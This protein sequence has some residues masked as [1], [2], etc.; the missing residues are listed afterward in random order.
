MKKI[1]LIELIKKKYPSIPEKESFARI[2]C[3]EVFVKGERVRDP[4]RR[5][6]EGAEP[7]FLSKKYVSRGGIKLESVLQRWKIEVR[8]KIFIDAGSST[9]GFTDCLLQ[10]GA[11]MVH[12]VDVGYNQLD[13]RLRTDARVKVYERTNIMAV[14]E[15]DPIPHAAVADLSFRKIGGAAGHLLDLVREGWLIALVKPQFEIKAEM[16]PEFSGVVRT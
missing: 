13:Y 15:L 11:R 3:G 10:N 4:H 12:S 14:G 6:D 16:D 2:L 8:D 9:G 7:Q 5:L 1:S